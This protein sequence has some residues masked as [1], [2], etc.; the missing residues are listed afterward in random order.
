M[1]GSLFGKVNV[2]RGALVTIGN[3]HRHIHDSKAWSARLFNAA[4]A[5][6]AYLYIQINIP[7]DYDANVNLK[8]TN[9]Y[10]TGTLA[11]FTLTEAPT[12]TDGTTLIVPRNRNRKKP[13]ASGLILF[14]DPT[15]I[16]GGTEL[17]SYAIGTG[18]NPSSGGLGEEEIEWELAPGTKYILQLQNN[19]VGVQTLYMRAFWYE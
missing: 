11:T 18:S 16:S 10:T 19:D 15:G 17:D 3:A 2:S 8:E 9:I 7:A 12:V 1:N 6:S 14:S 4:L 5:A 13:D